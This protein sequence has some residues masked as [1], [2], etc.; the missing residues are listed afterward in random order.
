[1]SYV[2]GRS[3]GKCHY[4][5]LQTPLNYTAGPEGVALRYGQSRGGR[6]H[7]SK[8]VL[9]RCARDANQTVQNLRT[10][11][12]RAAALT[13]CDCFGISTSFAD[14]NAPRPTAP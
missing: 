4:P 14:G 3:W 6:K 13:A 11:G 10:T 7:D 8:P 12:A 5:S 1:M 2:T 9:A